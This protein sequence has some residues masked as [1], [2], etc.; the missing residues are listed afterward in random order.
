MK[1]IVVVSFIGFSLVACGENAARA[2]GDTGGT[3]VIL[4]KQDPGTLFPP[5]NTTTEARQI[6]EQIY[7][8]LADVGPNLNT[9]DDKTFRPQLASSWSWSADSLQISFHINPRARW[10][11][12]QR[13]SAHDVAFT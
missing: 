13:A 11:D 4:A 9:C 8:Y 2:R 5:I 6:C 3:I 7:D 1:E 10:H 12:G